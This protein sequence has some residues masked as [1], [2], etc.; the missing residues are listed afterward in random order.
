MQKQKKNI[1]AM[2]KKAI[3]EKLRHIAAV[4]RLIGIHRIT[5]HSDYET[6]LDFKEVEYTDSNG[7]NVGGME[8]ELEEDALDLL[9]MFCI[10]A[11]QSCDDRISTEAC[12]ISF[13]FNNKDALEGY[14]LFDAEKKES[15]EYSDSLATLLHGNE[16]RHYSIRTL[17]KENKIH[18]IL[19]EFSGGNDSGGFDY[20]DFYDK[21][22]RKLS[23][24]DKIEKQVW[25]VVE[26]LVWDEMEVFGFNGDFSVSGSVNIS[27]EKD[28]DDYHVEMS[29][30][31]WSNQTTSETFSLPKY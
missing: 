8:I 29:K 5:S 1:A 6:P 28:I 24:T 21:K 11:L 27:Y 18:K 26:K 2:S 14:I 3:A 7:V 19:G 31:E 17:L 25:D 22:D 13:R 4:M 30:D 9:K 23:L 16:E 20:L 12:S 10:P 15:G